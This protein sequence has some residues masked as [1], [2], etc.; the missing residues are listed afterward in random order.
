MEIQIQKKMLHLCFVL[1]NICIQNIWV[2]TLFCRCS[3]EPLPQLL[4]ILNTLHN[5]LRIVSKV[6]RYPLLLKYIIVWRTF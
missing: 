6:N 1:L 4:Y 2:C 5:I 3:L